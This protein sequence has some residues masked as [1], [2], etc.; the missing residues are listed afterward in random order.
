MP[1]VEEVERYGFAE[2]KDRLSAL[3]ASAN[4][5]GRPFVITKNNKP[6]AEVRPLAVRERREG[7]VTIT[8]LRREVAVPDL[9]DVFAGYDGGYV[10]REDGFAAPAGAEA[11]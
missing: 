11:M 1:L 9:D 3:T 6:W 4:E 8:P 2:A 5:T 10:A 7:S